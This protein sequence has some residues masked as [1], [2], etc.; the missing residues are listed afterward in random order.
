MTPVFHQPEL[1]Q[2]T[3]LQH[4]EVFDRIG[5][6]QDRALELCGDPTRLLPALVVAERQTA[7]RGRDGANWWSPEG[8][9]L[10]S[11]IVP[12]PPKFA[13]PD[14]SGQLSLAVA[15]AMAGYLKE[16][17]QS[18]GHDQAVRVKRPNDVY[19]AD[20]KIAGLLIDVPHQRNRKRRLAVLGI[21]LNVNN[22]CGNC[23]AEIEV[24]VASIGELTGRKHDLQAS[25]ISLLG[26]IEKAVGGV[27][28]TANLRNSGL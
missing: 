14:R 18:S 17:L 4:V 21:G 19:V 7:G 16:M 9:L 5:S 20:A 25:L 13:Q 6:T 23:P 22:D 10:C 12:L 11:L 27:A 1:L 2:Q 3:F 8:A 26:Y 28:A 24:P 15:E